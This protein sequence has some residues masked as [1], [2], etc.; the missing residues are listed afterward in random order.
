MHILMT[1]DTVGGVWTYTR[2]LVTG[3][4][5]RGHSITLVSFGKLPSKGQTR[6]MDGLN[7]VQFRPTEY[8]L[9]WMQD[10]ERDIEASRF[11]LAELIAEIK[12]DLLHFNQYAYGSL[13]TD[14]PRVVVAHSDVVSWWTAVHGEEPRED[15]W[16]RW[17]G[18]TVMEGLKRAS[19]VV[20]PSETMLRA[21]QRHYLQPRVARVIHNGRDPRLFDPHREKENVV[22]SVGRIWDQAKQVSL[23]L[24]QEQS[25]PVW[26]VG[27]QEHPE[28]LPGGFVENN[29][30][31]AIQFLG[32]KSEDELIDLYARAGVYAATARYEPFGLAAV[33]AAFSGCALILNDIDSLRE[34]WGDAGY[35]F[36]R[37]SSQSLAKA[38]R[39]LGCNSELRREYAQRAYQH[40]MKHFQA[41]RM[42]EEYE[43]LCR[44]LVAREAAA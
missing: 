28:G 20:A 15:T 39:E 18:P 17:Y 25:L 38:I 5:H 23:L 31:S 14:A 30:G 29:K 6:W 27:S 33:E 10:S 34:L 3:L 24:Q 37:N 1:A 11:F 16:I 40:A 43:A 12:P 32:A 13:L 36:C 7:S 41:E 2:E 35:Y 42:V 21:I 8:R 4:A 44:N 22:L 26:M 9:E 19:A